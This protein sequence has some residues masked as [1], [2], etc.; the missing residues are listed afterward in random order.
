MKLTVE[1]SRKILAERGWCLAEACDKCGKLLGAVR[2]TI[3]AKAG[4]WCSALCRDGV[5]PV[6]I[7]VCHGCGSALTGMRRGT[8]FCGDTCRKRDAKRNAKDRPDYRG[9]ALESKPLTEPGIGLGY[10]ATGAA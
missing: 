4:E 1:Q 5:E 6:P 3:R 9:M 2:Y 10:S 7:G 8:K